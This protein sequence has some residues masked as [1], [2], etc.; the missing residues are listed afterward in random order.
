MPS[1][2]SLAGRSWS[3]TRRRRRS[4]PQTVVRV[5][6]RR[7]SRSRSRACSTACRIS[8]SAGQVHVDQHQVDPLAV[9]RI[10]R[11]CPPSDVATTST[12]S[13]LSAIAIPSRAISL[14]SHTNTRGH[15]PTLDGVVRSGASTIIRAASSQ[16][17][18][19]WR[20]SHTPR[21]TV[22]RSYDA[23]PAAAIRRAHDH[24]LPQVS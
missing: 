4:A 13:G 24:G 17:S 11:T 18:E 12:P 14:G 6:P 9:D 20:V 2:H 1:A 22:A 16:Y 3:G 21:H 10:E 23:R 8:S 7:R 15:D 19:P 5:P